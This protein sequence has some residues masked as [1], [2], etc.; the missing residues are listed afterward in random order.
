MIE[1]KTKKSVTLRLPN[2]ALVVLVGP[3]GSGKSQFARDHFF[4]LR[5][6]IVSSDA[7][8]RL[9][10]GNLSQ[11]LLQ[12]FSEGAFMVFHSWIRARLRHNLFTIA[13]STAA[14]RE[15]RE[16]LEQIAKEEHVP[17]RYIYFATSFEEC[18]KRDQDR[19]VSDRVEESVIKR[20]FAKLN[21]ARSWLKNE[22]SVSTVKFGEE[23]EISLSSVDLKIDAPAID[24]VGDIHGC[25]EEMIELIEKLGYVKGGWFENEHEVYKH[26]EGRK[27]VFVGDLVDRGPEPYKVLDFVKRH[28][29]LGLADLVLSNHE[30]KLRK[31]V[32]SRKVTMNPD[33]QK[34]IDSFPADLDKRALKSFLYNLKPYRTWKDPNSGKD[35]VVAHAAFDPKFYGKVDG[36]IEGYCVYGPNEGMDAE[37]GFPKRI[38][39]WETYRSNIGVVYGHIVTDDGE[40]RVV[41]NTFGIDTACVFGK[42]LTSLR[43]PE[44]EFVSVQAKQAYCEDKAPRSSFSIPSDLSNVPSID[45]LLESSSV[46]VQSPTGDP[47]KIQFRKGLVDAIDTMS[48]YVSQP[49]KLIWLAPNI[50]PGPVSDKEDLMEDPITTARYMFDNAP[51][52]VFIIAEEKFMGSR[53]T[54]RAEKKDGKWDI[55][56]FTRNGRD[57]FD[58]PFRSQI[59]SAMQPVFEEIGRKL[60]SDILLLDSE[61]MPWNQRGPAW[62]EKLY[63]TTAAA[64]HVSRYAILSALKAGKLTTQAERFQSNLDNIIKF[65]NVASSYCWKVDKV[66]ELKVGFFDILYPLN[67]LTHVQKMLMFKSLSSPFLSHCE[68][69]TFTDTSQELSELETFWNKLT[70][71]GVEGVVLKFDD[72]KIWTNTD[73]PQQQFK[74]RGKE[75]LRLIYS[76]NYTNP[77]IMRQ[78]KHNRNNRSKMRLAYNQTLLGNEALRRFHA[79]EPLEKI[80]EAVLGILASEFS[81]LVDPRL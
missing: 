13:D 63:M 21:Q 26:P 1:T 81:T 23:V 14:S 66:E 9:L 73:T 37:T 58:E 68:F 41:N 74:V 47:V 53:G 29:E 67:T 80:H 36:A 35:W 17:I 11:P 72:P 5:E 54:W 18:V 40:P 4:H 38:A 55:F 7:C 6:S 2:N 12:K 22:S 34:T 62:L 77:E 10:V 61:V 8:R 32:S 28:V 16:Q 64:A 30:R 46:L 70:S 57:M 49:D 39:W 50:S 71:K 52:G 79:K 33:L 56:C 60:Q 65:G 20:Q 45:A 24:V 42:K 51:K 25:S 76:P 43:L 19:E 75:Y 59:Y 69:F 3:S 78:L 48:S 31:W 15:S 27:L 44:Q